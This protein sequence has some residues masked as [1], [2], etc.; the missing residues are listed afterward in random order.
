MTKKTIT[1]EETKFVDMST[2]TNNETIGDL[3]KKHKS[4]N[5]L[6]TNLY[7]YV[8]DYLNE[9]TSDLF[10]TS[11]KCTT[12]S[13]FAKINEDN[14]VEVYDG[15]G[16]NNCYATFD[17]DYPVVYVFKDLLFK[18]SKDVELCMMYLRKQRIE[19]SEIRIWASDY[20]TYTAL[21]EFA[22][23]YELD[24]TQSKDNGRPYIDI[25]GISPLPITSN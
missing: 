12:L 11:M 10:Y 8:V 13:L 22:T 4:K 2:N 9:E 19:C 18:M 17:Y 3:V 23:D 21:R 25:I 5:S 15:N 24:I 20:K 16:N 1:N 14:V 7:P 6:L